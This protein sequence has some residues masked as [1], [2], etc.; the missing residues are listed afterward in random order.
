MENKLLIKV[1]GM[2]HPENINEISSLGIDFIGFIFHKPSSRYTDKSP[3]NIKK[4]KAKKVGVFVN[5]TEEEITRRAKEF[6]LDYLQLHGGESVEFCDNLQ[7]QGFKIIKVFSLDDDF[8]FGICKDFLEVSDLFLFDTKGKNP[9]G[10]GVIFNWEKL[11][12]YDLEKPFLLSG[13]IGIN[14]IKDIRKFNHPQLLGLDLNSGFEISPGLKNYKLLK[15][16]LHEIR[17]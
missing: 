17:H 16:F 8:N 1:C 7:K 13:G 14:N 10:N 6:E 4:I 11:R 12:E 9:G 15:D 3:Y 5:S 2:K